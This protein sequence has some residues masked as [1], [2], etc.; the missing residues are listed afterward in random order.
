MATWGVESDEAVYDRAFVRARGSDLAGNLAISLTQYPSR[1]SVLVL[2][3]CTQVFGCF[4]KEDELP[5]VHSSMFQETKRTGAVVV[6]RERFDWT[7]I[8][9]KVPQTCRRRSSY[10]KIN[11]TTEQTCSQGSR[12]NGS[13]TSLEGRRE[14]WAS[15]TT[16]FIHVTD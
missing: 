8:K 6:S 9:V 7:L 14:N 2:H 13:N 16:S 3:G 11:C 10:R 4:P 1:I 5:N 12:F 15:G